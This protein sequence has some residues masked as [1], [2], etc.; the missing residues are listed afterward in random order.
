MFISA[1]LW[2][3]RN[4]T[5]VL[6]PGGNDNRRQRLLND[7][8]EESANTSKIINC[9]CVWPCKLQARSEGKRDAW[10]KGSTIERKN[11]LMGSGAFL[12]SLMWTTFLHCVTMLKSDWKNC[13]LS[14]FVCLFV[15]Q[16]QWCIWQNKR[17]GIDQCQ[18]KDQCIYNG[19]VQA[20]TRRSM[21]PHRG[22]T[23]SNTI[24]PE[25]S[26]QNDKPKSAKPRKFPISY[27]KNRKKGHGK[28]PNDK[29][30]NCLFC[31]KSITCTLVQTGRFLA[32]IGYVAP[33]PRP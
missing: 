31:L 23:R 2:V 11:R 10:H 16:L 19:H 22:G 28:A 26:P 9:G 29:T 12:P 1:C 6:L 8:D 4:P 5:A 17:Y 13:K 27:P 18:A 7:N 20:L 15:N 30:R 25:T 21:S 3:P 33:S 14:V 32:T 24:P